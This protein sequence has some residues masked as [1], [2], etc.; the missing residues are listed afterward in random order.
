MAFDPQVIE[1]ARQ[2]REIELTTYGR[3]SG[4]PTRK[5]L[6]VG[7]DGQHI[8]VRSG[9][10][11][12][13]DWPRN[14]LANGRAVLHIAGRDIPVS[15]DHV[16]DPGQARQVTELYREKYGSTPQRP[17]DGGPTPAEQATFELWPAES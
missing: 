9:Q 8:F 16:V 6:W 12:N 3:N 7:T 10:G 2:D 14:A 1:A 13:R 15:V 11:L 17:P 4:R 5:I